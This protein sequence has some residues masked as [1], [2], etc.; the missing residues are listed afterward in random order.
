MKRGFSEYA[1]SIKRMVK[2]QSMSVLLLLLDGLINDYDKDTVGVV[3][4][5]DRS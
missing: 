4:C 2:G 1:L 3:V 5:L